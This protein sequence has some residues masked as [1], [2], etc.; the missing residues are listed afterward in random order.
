MMNAIAKHG[1][2]KKEVIF[3]FAKAFTVYKLSYDKRRKT[4]NL[5]F[6]DKMTAAKGCR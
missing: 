4:K 5:C 3:I 6:S 2:I 1:G